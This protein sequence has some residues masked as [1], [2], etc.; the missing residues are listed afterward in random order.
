M[1]NFHNIFYAKI[2]HYTIQFSLLHFQLWSHCLNG[3]FYRFRKKFYFSHRVYELTE[4]APK[5]DWC[6]FGHMARFRAATGKFSKCLLISSKERILMV[7]VGLKSRTWFLPMLFTH[8]HT[9]KMQ[10]VGNCIIHTCILHPFHSVSII[11]KYVLK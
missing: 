10:R 6:W 8:L 4:K 1:F 5:L 7:I 3:F 11:W 9:A 2:F